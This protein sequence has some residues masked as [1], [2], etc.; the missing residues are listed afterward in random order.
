VFQPLGHAV[1]VVV[2]AAQGQQL[3]LI[4]RLKLH[5]APARSR[6]ALQH[7][8]LAR[9]TCTQQVHMEAILEKYMTNE[10]ST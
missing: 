6:H 9:R 3:D 2:V 10:S 7:K 5:P 4:L 8:L 1:W